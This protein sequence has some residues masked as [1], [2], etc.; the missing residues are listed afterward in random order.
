MRFVSHHEIEWGLIRD[1]V[2][3]V[4]VSEFGMGD[5]VSPGIRVGPTED[6]KVCFNLLVDTFCFTVGLRVVGSGEGEVVV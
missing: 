5:F 4:I 2:W 1:G 6:P 3:A